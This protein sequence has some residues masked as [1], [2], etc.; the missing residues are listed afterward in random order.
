M[1]EY[2]VTEERSLPHR[3]ELRSGSRAVNRLR[4]QQAIV[5]R[6]SAASPASVTSAGNGASTVP[7]QMGWSGTPH[8]PQLSD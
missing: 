7:S 6:E 3:T 4:Y 1:S 5:W 8:R 2:D